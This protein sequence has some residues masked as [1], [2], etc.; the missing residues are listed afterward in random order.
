MQE[1]LLFGYPQ[2]QPK[3]GYTLNQKGNK[4]FESIQ[5]SKERASSAGT[6]IKANSFWKTNLVQYLKA[7]I[8]KGHMFYSAASIRYSLLEL[9]TSFTEGGHC[10]SSTRT[11]ETTERVH[12]KNETVRNVVTIHA[13]GSAFHRR[14]RTTPGGVPNFAGT[15]RKTFEQRSPGAL[16]KNEDLDLEQ[17][18]QRSHSRKCPVL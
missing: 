1:L 8:Q 9:I 3:H 5:F 14:V 16:Q 17:L 13:T 4:E 10:S 7:H 11:D 12:R 15:E 2:C 6:V 18:E